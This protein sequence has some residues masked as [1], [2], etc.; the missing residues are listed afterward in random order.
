MDYYES[1]PVSDSATIMTVLLSTSIHA[2]RLP[3]KLYQWNRARAGTQQRRTR[4]PL[5]K[6]VYIEPC[7]GLQV[8]EYKVLLSGIC[9]SHQK[10][11]ILRI[12]EDDVVDI[13]T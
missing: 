9:C 7:N 5:N 13:Y 8:F 2:R 4:A 11:D 10:E 1:K 12:N 6:D 3:F